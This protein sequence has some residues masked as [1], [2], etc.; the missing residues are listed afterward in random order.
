[1]GRRAAGLAAQQGYTQ[2][3]VYK[4]GLQDW[5][6]ARG[7]VVVDREYVSSILDEHHVVVDV[8]PGDAAAQGRLPT[9]VSAP[10]S[11]MQELDRAPGPRRTLPGLRDRLAPIVLYGAD[12]REGEQ[13]AAL[14]AAWGF[15]NIAVLD[16]GYPSWSGAGLPTSSG[17]PPAQVNYSRKVLKG[18]ISAEDFRALATSGQAVVLDVREDDEVAHGRIPGSVHIP[19]GKL[20]ERLGELSPDAEIIIHCAVGVRA[21]MAYIR[22]AV[23][24]FKHVRFLDATISVQP[25]GTFCIDCAE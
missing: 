7:L 4:D 5:R 14:L 25:D 17:A 23:R 20:D 9:A 16:G 1:M 24:G 11:R 12:R 15:S 6:K 8:R 18:T 10:L 19:L 2:V 13:A 3:R 22:L 21:R